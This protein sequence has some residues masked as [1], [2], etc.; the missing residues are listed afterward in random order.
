M[1]NS[2]SFVAF[3]VF[4]VSWVFTFGYMSCVTINNQKKLKEQDKCNHQWISIT[5]NCTV[6]CKKYETEKCSVCG[7]IRQDVMCPVCQKREDEHPSP[8][9]W[10]SS[11]TW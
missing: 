2:L 5:K 4:I 8:F 10:P 9:I 3:V 6:C 1:K 7:K 11:S